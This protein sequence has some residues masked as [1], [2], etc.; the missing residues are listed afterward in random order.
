MRPAGATLRLFAQWLHPT[1]THGDRFYLSPFFYARK[2]LFMRLPAFWL[3]DAMGQ[4]SPISP[5]ERGFSLFFLCSLVDA[6]F[7]RGQYP[8]GFQRFGLTMPLDG[9]RKNRTLFL[10]L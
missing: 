7:S 3:V 8:C 10:F 2:P 9:H 6:S 1:T 5:P 4:I